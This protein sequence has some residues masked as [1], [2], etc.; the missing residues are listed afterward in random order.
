MGQNAQFHQPFK[1]LSLGSCGWSR[2]LL[3][4]DRQLPGGAGSG[5]PRAPQQQRDEGWM[6]Q[7]QGFGSQLWSATS[8]S[9]NSTAAICDLGEHGCG[10]AL[11]P[12]VQCWPLFNFPVSRLLKPERFCPQDQC[13]FI[14]Q[15][16]LL[17]GGQC[18]RNARGDCLFVKT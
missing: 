4:A 12:A 13:L 17:P 6:G 1:N 3:G 7:G 18:Y 9:A 15:P 14:K 10:Q 5:C 11:V 16:M 8:S 2:G